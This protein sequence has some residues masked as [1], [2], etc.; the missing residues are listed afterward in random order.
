MRKILNLFFPILLILILSVPV[1]I[2]LL[3]SGY[4]PTHDGEWA[5]VRLGDMFRT[6]RD[7]QFPPR[8]S[9]AL[10]FGYGYPLFN[11]AYPFPYY[12]GILVYFVTHSFIASIKIL[13]GLSVVLSAICMYFAS[14]KL[15]NNKTAALLSALSY[16]YFPYRIVDLYVRGSLGESIAFVFFPLIF[17]L[18]LKLFDDPFNRFVVFFLSVSIGGLILTHNIMSVLYFP[19]LAAYFAIKIIKE[20]RND[21]LQTFSLSFV[22]GIGISS[23]F[24][25]PAL[26]EKGNIVL[27]KVPIADRSLYFINPVSLIYSKWGYGTPTDIN[28]FTYE[29]GIGQMI[30][31]FLAV[32][33]LT[34]NLIKKRLPLTP[35]M[36]QTSVLIVISILYLILTFEIS[37]PIWKITPLFSEINYP[38][39]ILSQL[40]FL[41][42][43]LVGF[44][45]IQGK[46]FKVVAFILI[47][48]SAI[49]LLPN[50]RPSSFSNNPDSYYLTNEATTTSSSELMPLWVKKKPSQRYVNKVEI[51]NGNAEISN[52]SY[53]SK[54]I[55]FN[56]KSDTDPIFKINTIY[57]PGWR[58]YV[59]GEEVKINYDNDMGIMELQANRYRNSVHLY[60]RE[61]FPRLASDII[62]VVSILVLMF[63]L[64]R[65]LL[66]FKTR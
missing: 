7:L 61:T 10:N 30:I 3:K 19:F 38:W 63:L 26:F 52:L 27:S 24:W 58:A 47:A 53:N 16:I 1:I 31:F 66:L 32:I 15:W 40:G 56:Y 57:Y 51:K 33:F 29:I 5:V 65:P 34:L 35:V 14:T 9:G 48:F 2:P 11:F 49:I 45:V 6:L 43:L 17:Y 12:L 8:M 36:F 59:S 39:T 13:F 46:Y 23:F 21:V 25:F 4:F 44:I 41:F 54:E 18:S 55:S 64:L 22:L 42:S 28:P 20:K 60:F 50:L 37:A 62:S